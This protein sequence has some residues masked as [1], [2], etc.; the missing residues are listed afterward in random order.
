MDAEALES[1]CGLL[2]ATEG[3]THGRPD[4]LRFAAW[5]AGLDAKQCALGSS[6]PQTPGFIKFKAQ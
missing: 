2:G 6:K 4:G 1:G 5:S 3:R